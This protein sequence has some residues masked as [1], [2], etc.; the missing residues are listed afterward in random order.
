VLAHRRASLSK[1][2][3][4]AGTL[5]T[6]VASGRL[7][8]I[9]TAPPQPPSE[10]KASSEHERRDSQF[11][12]SQFDDIALMLARAQVANDL[13]YKN[14]K[15]VV[16]EGGSLHAD[17]DTLQSLAD[18]TSP[19]AARPP[20][21]SMGMAAGAGSDS[22]ASPHEPLAEAGL[23]ASRDSYKVYPDGDE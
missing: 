16:I 13:L 7:A 12:D 8:P 21:L 15:R 10:T 4:A 11:E 19:T 5:P 18:V 2:G 3:G 9:A 20:R 14:P 23:G 22:G 1:L 17:R 6:P